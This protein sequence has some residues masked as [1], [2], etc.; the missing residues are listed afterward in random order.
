MQACPL[1]ADESSGALAIHGARLCSESLAIL[2]N[3]WPGASQCRVILTKLI[4]LQ[5]QKWSWPTESDAL[6]PSDKEIPEGLNWDSSNKLAARCIP[7]EGQFIQRSPSVGSVHLPIPPLFPPVAP[8]LR[9]TQNLI[10]PSIPR[11]EAS[12]LSV[13]SELASLRRLFED[14]PS[15]SKAF[16]TRFRLLANDSL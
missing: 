6:W 4:S 5:A 12:D 10:E 16:H 14:L 8:V 2:E 11:H 15:N 1:Y 7:G 3:S 9:S 13:L